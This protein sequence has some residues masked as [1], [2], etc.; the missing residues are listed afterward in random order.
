MSVNRIRLRAALL[1]APLAV[2]A[3]VSAGALDPASAAPT[4][5]VKL[6]H[7]RFSPATVRITRGTVVRWHWLDGAVGTHNVTSKGVRGGLRFRGT[8]TKTSGFY[9]VTFTKRG[10]YYYECTV[11]PLT[12]QGKIIVG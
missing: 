1:L 7:F 6:Q 12:M 2:L 3:G 10:T 5:G 9:S 8:R 11:H 4:V